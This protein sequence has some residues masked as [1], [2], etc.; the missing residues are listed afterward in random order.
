[1]PCC[2]IIFAV[3]SVKMQ[4]SG[5]AKLEVEIVYMTAS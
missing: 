5:H 4:T 1:M 3:C 2:L